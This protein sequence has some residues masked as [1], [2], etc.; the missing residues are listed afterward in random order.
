MLPQEC[1]SE[2][3]G[4]PA[5]YVSCFAHLCVLCALTW[6]A[7]FNAHTVRL[8]V[9]TVHAGTDEPVREPHFLYVPM[10]NP[11]HT[12]S[13]RTQAKL[14][15][16]EKPRQTQSTDSAGYTPTTVPTELLSMLDT[17][18]LPEPVA[19][20][21]PA[22]TRTMPPLILADTSIPPP[23]PPPGEPDIKPPPV[24]GGRVE[25]AQLIKQAMPEYPPL[26]RKARVEGVVVLEGTVNVS[27]SVE[28]VRVVQGHPMLIEE[29]MKA[30]KK[31]KYRPAM[32]NGEP[33]PC[34]VI[35]TVRF[36]LRYP[37]AVQ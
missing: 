13:N 10:S 36:T 27:G 20:I 8:E 24:I 18:N 31:W 6:F 25:A 14:P 15:V 9:T 28:N 3:P 21:A 19:G 37:E 33:T 7:V 26:A 22:G 1:V 34:P 4:K 23:E 17:N 11:S 29:A 12:P 2:T 16:T 5:L 30:V 35:V 32:L